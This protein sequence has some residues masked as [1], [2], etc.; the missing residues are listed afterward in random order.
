MIGKQPVFTFIGARNMLNTNAV[1]TVQGGA[2]TPPTLL[3]RDA[4]RI[5][6][7]GKIRPGI[8][9]LTKKASENAQALDIYSR[10]VAAG[11]T[12]EQIERELAKALPE[13]KKPLT[14]RN[15]PWFTLNPLDF[16]NPEVARQILD[17]Y[18]EDRGEGMRLYRFPAVFPADQWQSIMPHEL[19][20]WGANEKRYWSQYSPDGQTRHCMRHAPV[21]VDH[22]GR[23]TVRLFGGRKV[24]MRGE[25]NGACNPEACAEYQARQCNLTGRFVFFIPGIRTINALELPTNSFYAMSNAIQRFQ[26]ISYMR[27]GRIAGFLGR[28][29][30]TFIFSKVLR[31]VPHIDES[32]R[33]VRVAHWIIEL[34]APVDVTALLREGEDEET[35][36][37]QAHFAANALEGC[38]SAGVALPASGSCTEPEVPATQPATPEKPA[39]NPTLEQILARVECFGIQPEQFLRYADENWGSGWRRNA[40]G[41]SR[42]WD[43]VERHQNDP[44]GYADKIDALLGV[45]A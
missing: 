35:V 23:R 6:T 28:E 1:V 5:P 12:F 30:A 29:G 43:E 4:P 7:G 20:C 38:A 32:G 2:D 45:P 39:E 13:L 34:E 8:K 40:H 41:R 14:P 37:A 19:A 27:G 17:A 16:P 31:E 33:V 21:P 25:N 3:G 42:V 10:G 22:N 18:G 26:A 44:E 11:K 9:V 24:L 15:V 36:I